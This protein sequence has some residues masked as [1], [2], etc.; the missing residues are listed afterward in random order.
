MCQNQEIMRL[1]TIQTTEFYDTLQKNGVVYCDRESWFC[2]EY[3]DMYDWMANEMRKHIGIP[4]QK[5]VRYPIWAWYQYTSRKKPRPPISSNMLDSD[6]K[7][8]VMLEIEIPDDKVL[9]SD[10]GLWHVP[11]NGHPIS[12]DKKLMKRFDA[13]R[14]VHGGSCDFEDY[15]ED[16]KSDIMVTWSVIFDLRTKLRRWVAKAM[17]NRSIQACFWELKL[18]QVVEVYYIKRLEK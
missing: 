11:L 8:G 1:W 16:L 10:F 3:R 2:Q 9:L 15:P 18:E 17:W 7:E 5:K 14:A 4:P 6:Q 13:F 12:D